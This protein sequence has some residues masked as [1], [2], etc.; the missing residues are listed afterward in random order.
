MCQVERRHRDKPLKIKEALRRKYR[1]LMC[2]VRVAREV[3]LMGVAPLS[4]APLSVSL[5]LTKGP[6]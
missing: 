5:V 3:N 1:E 4:A 6:A 2:V